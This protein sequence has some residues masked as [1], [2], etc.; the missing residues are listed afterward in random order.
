MKEIIEQAEKLGFIGM[1]HGL[2]ED[3]DFINLCLIQRWL[4]KKG[5]DVDV[6]C[7][8]SG[9]GY[10]LNKTNGTSLYHFDM[11][12]DTP[13]GMYETHDQALLEGVKEGLK[14]LGDE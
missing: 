12:A 2:R 5:V 1:I 11:D 9:W 8:A 10:N 6:W 14:M 3:I 4:R 7:N 13:S